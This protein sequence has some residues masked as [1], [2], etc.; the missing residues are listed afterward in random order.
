MKN[1]YKIVA[2]YEYNNNKFF[3]T[4][5]NNNKVVIVKYDE[6][7]NISTNFTDEE[8]ELLNTVYNSLLINRKEAVFIKDERVKN[9]QYKIYYDTSSKNYFWDSL[10]G[11]DNETCNEILNLKYNNRLGV[12]HLEENM[13]KSIE[14]LLNEALAKLDKATD[15]SRKKVEDLRNGKKT[16]ETKEENED[17]EEELVEEQIAEPEKDEEQ[18]EEQEIVSEEANKT[19]EEQIVLIVEGVKEPETSKEETEPIDIKEVKEVSNDATRTE[20]EVTYE[21]PLEDIIKEAIGKAKEKRENDPRFIQENKKVSEE[22]D[23]KKKERS[24]YYSKFVKFKKKIIPILVS[25]TMLLMPLIDSIVLGAQGTKEE[26]VGNGHGV[27]N[28]INDKMHKLVGYKYQKIE[29]AI[30]SNENLTDGE[31]EYIN[32]FETVF[33]QDYMFMDLDLIEERMA[34]LKI[35]YISSEE[36]QVED[37][38]TLAG[39]YNELTNEITMNKSTDFESTNKADFSHELF[40]VWQN[41]SHRYIM[42][43]INEG[44]KREK[45][46]DMR[47]KGIFDKEDFIDNTETYSNYGNGYSDH[48]YIYYILASMLD[49]KDIKEYQY[50]CDDKIIVSKLCEIDKNT[51]ANAKKETAYQLLDAIDRIRVWDNEAQ[52]YRIDLE[53]EE[54]CKKRLNYYFKQKNGMDIEEDLNCVIHKMYYSEATYKAIEA[55]LIGENSE[56][57]DKILGPWKTVLP[58]TYTS[59]NHPN[60]SITFTSPEPVTIEITDELCEKYKKNY[61]KMKSKQKDEGR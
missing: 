36:N 46:R 55:T 53:A 52:C 20:L 7:K 58:K 5:V 13:E 54:E 35:N 21:K 11:K 16:E 43:L 1:S 51:N 8:Y 60:A 42:E 44:Y 17:N 57:T 28:V 4:L 2:K 14:D 38:S 9:R 56:D 19:D 61:E 3:I 6:N 47:D 30:N 23:E 32:K 26:K 24:G 25:S 41:S 50:T 39:S 15:E 33:N 59:D 40:H 29:D 31:K 12:Y 22:T 45:L 27:L 48:M 37:F 34:T 49:Q 18:T 10:D